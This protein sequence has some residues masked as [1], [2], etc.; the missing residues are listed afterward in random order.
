MEH[1]ERHLTDGNEMV[2]VSREL[3]DNKRQPREPRSGTS[4]DERRPTIRYIRFIITSVGYADTHTSTMHWPKL[5]FIK[6]FKS[7]S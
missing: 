1:H 5:P 7:S 6:L 2:T 3:H 4:T